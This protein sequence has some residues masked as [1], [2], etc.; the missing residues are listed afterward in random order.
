MAANQQAPE[1]E[2]V[3]ESF[4]E[5]VEEDQ[6]GGFGNV[7]AWTLLVLIVVAFGLFVA[8]VHMP[9]R[10]ENIEA[11]ANVIQ[12]TDET[13]GLQVEL[14]T[15]EKKYGEVAAQLAK[16]EAD[17]TRM[18]GDLDDK[19]AALAAL[20]SSKNE[21][22]ARLERE[23]ATGDISIARRGN[24]LVVGV[25][26]KI[27]FNTGE[28]ALNPRGQ[29]VLARVAEIMKKNNRRFQVGGHTDSVPVAGSL[30]ER[31]P[32]NWELSAARAIQV[33]RYLEEECDVPG[34]RLLATGFSRHR[35]VANNRSPQ[36]RR[37]NRRIEI[38]MLSGKDR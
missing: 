19:A 18:K 16:V 26:D 29:A 34:D 8:V 35:P 23:I 25:S 33:V 17:R 37:R 27:L 7:V 12:C 28:A 21:L 20:E 11:Q 38:V 3:H 24:Q 2:F 9:E 15:S 13:S 30:K 5:D 22:E 32:T 6:G 10:E 36:G 14:L 31:Y 4:I 1:P